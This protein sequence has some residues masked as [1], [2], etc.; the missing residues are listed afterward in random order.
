MRSRL[1]WSHLLCGL[2]GAIGLW[3]GFPGEAL[4]QPL[5]VVPLPPPGTTD[6]RVLT[7]ADAADR[8][9]VLTAGEAG[10]VRMAPDLASVNQFWVLGPVGR[11]TYRLQLFEAGQLWSL[12]ASG[13]A[14]GAVLVPSARDPRQLWRVIPSLSMNGAARL[15]SVAYP[16]RSLAGARDSIVTLER[17]SGGPAQNWLLQTKPLPPRL[18]IPT[19][20][21]AEHAIRP[22]PPLE[23]VTARLVNSHQ[24]E[25]WVLIRDFGGGLNLD[26]AAGRPLRIRPGEAIDLEIKRD[27]GAT[28]V[29]TYEVVSPLGEIYREE[30]VTSL[31]PAP[32]YDIAVYERFLQSIAIDRTG[33]S[34][35]PIEDIN[36]QPKSLGSFPIPP[37][38]RFTGGALDVYRLAKAA[39]NAGGVPHLVPDSPQP[40]ESARDPLQKALE[41]AGR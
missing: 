15:E 7:T 2:L 5:G 10:T 28:L 35:N 21:I 31:P 41:E 24:N 34:P 18:V 32:L 33:K 17:N 25:L 19:V 23:P 37:G 3:L 30:F 6:V 4:S 29:E 39:D 8:R 14:G 9:L 36:Y 11:D 26:G 13:P 20:R 12:S 27:S 22:A 1:V 38:E 16:S 40:L